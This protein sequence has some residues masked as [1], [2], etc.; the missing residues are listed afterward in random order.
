ML[1][2]SLE[3]IFL[4]LPA[5][6]SIFFILTG[7]RWH[8]VAV[9][10]LIAASVFFYGYW[11]PRYLPLLILSVLVNYAFAV[12]LGRD[13]RKWILAIGIIFNLGLLGYFKYA[14]F[15]IA[16]VPLLSLS[17]IHVVLPIAISFYT[18]EQIA[19]LV[20]NYRDTAPQTDFLRY[21]L[22][23]TFFP[24]LIAGPIVRGREV[25][26]QFE[27]SSFL[28][29]S[30][31]QLATGLTIF[32]IG[33]FKK[34]VFADNVA[35]YATHVFKM[36]ED[37]GALTF[38]DAWGG[39]LAF[40]VQIYFD[41]SGYSD[42]AL[43]IARMFG[44]S[45]PLNFNSPYKAVS[46]IE[47]W[48]RWHMTLSRFLRDYLYIPMGGDRKGKGRRY[49]NLLATMLLGG[50]W[51]GAGWTFVVWGAMHGLYLVI[52]HAWRSART[53]WGY[54]VSRST[55]WGRFASRTITLLAVIVAWIFFRASSFAGAMNVLAGMSG[56][57]GAGGISTS[58][59]G[60]AIAPFLLLICLV[61]PNSQEMV[62][63]VSETST[64]ALDEV[65]REYGTGLRWK[66]N[67]R[68]GLAVGLMFYFALASLTKGN[69]FV[70]FQF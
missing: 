61:A 49:L 17:S 15:L 36:A 18:F 16:N 45:L 41:F 1:F 2:N 39:V 67:L 51:H 23:I 59:I 3:F 65:K 26:P 22:F 10:W 35:P 63:R 32:V 50:L 46:I 54:D 31:T 69:E 43:G 30:T 4:F 12:V 40:T 20:D 19:Y 52:N 21:C 28:S 25:L 57:N 24:R 11:N 38:W 55:W 13:K 56:V 8:Q 48:R 44:I 68:W 9:A 60:Y 33:L 47:F 7:A 70:Y 5:T 53:A 62:D 58:L 42:M 64:V 34:V 37:G 29:F 6:A 27:R 66:P 14:N